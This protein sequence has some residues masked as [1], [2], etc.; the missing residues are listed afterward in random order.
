[1]FFLFGLAPLPQ[2][3]V[4]I[5]TQE[6]VS[7]SIEIPTEVETKTAVP[8]PASSPPN[9]VLFSEEIPISLN[10]KIKQKISAQLI[11]L[12]EEIIMLAKLVWREAR[13]IK[14]TQEQAAVIWCVLNRVDNGKY[15]GTIK[16]VVTARNQ[17]AYIKRTPVEDKFYNLARDVISRWLLEKEGFEDVGR[18]LPKE[19]LFFA[20]SRGRNRF[21]EK[22]SSKKYWDWSLLNPYN[23][24]DIW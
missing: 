11:E 16:E 22:Y 12:D 5:E 17:F 9:I 4:D 24:C 23:G 1:M 18:V 3:Q 20:G 2:T 21:R 8:T 6:A 10:K 14:S 15:G 13:G 19:Y 7:S